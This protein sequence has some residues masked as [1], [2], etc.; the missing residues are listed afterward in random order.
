MGK[1][2]VLRFNVGGKEDKSTDVW[3]LWA[4]GDD[5]Y[6]FT[7]IL[8]HRIHISLHKSGIWKLDLDS[9]RYYLNKE[10]CIADGWGRGPTLIFPTLHTKR[11]EVRGKHLNDKK[12]IILPSAPLHEIRAIHLLFQRRIGSKLEEVVPDFIREKIDW[13]EYINLETMGSL[14]VVSF[15]EVPSKDM[16]GY[17]YS[18]K[19]KT[20]FTLNRMPLPEEGFY[21]NAIMIES[22]K[23]GSHQSIIIS[24]PLDID[25][26][27]IEQT[28]PPD[29]SIPPN[30]KA[31]SG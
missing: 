6:L 2:K 5:V 27:Q 7:R 18:I 13:H 19:E 25:N 22:P 23:D 24:I 3:R 16:I 9:N 31:S 10:I 30:A 29:N 12:I 28:T 4:H 14:H 26:C 21:T 17:Y 1:K 11:F 20:K 15:L 8:S